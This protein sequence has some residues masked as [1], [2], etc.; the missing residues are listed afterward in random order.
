LFIHADITILEAYRRKDDANMNRMIRILS[1]LTLLVPL[2]ACGAQQSAETEETEEPAVTE[3]AEIEETAKPEETKEEGKALIAYFSR[4][5][6]N[7]NVGVIEEGN[8]YKSPKK[9][10][11][12]PAA[13]SLKSAP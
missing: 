8:T 4:A 10:R 2:A 13:I 9:S 12:R 3:E 1:A 6:E 5:D 11:H 7:Y